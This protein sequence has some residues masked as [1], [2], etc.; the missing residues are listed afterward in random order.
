MSKQNSIKQIQY[1]NSGAQNKALDSLHGVGNIT[2]LD[3][4]LQDNSCLP[5]H[6]LV[7]FGLQNEFRSA[8][9]LFECLFP[10]SVSESLEVLIDNIRG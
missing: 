2:G 7:I 1:T 4:M 8:G 10:T 5:V 3:Q 9:F 6:I